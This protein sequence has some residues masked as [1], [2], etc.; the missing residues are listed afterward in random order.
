VAVVPAAAAAALLAVDIAETVL[1]QIV[2]QLVATTISAALAPEFLELQQLS[3]KL[4]NTRA[5][6]P[7]LSI[8]AFIKGHRSE[9]DSKDDVS[10]TGF[11][12]ELWK[13]MADTAGE[14]LPLL[15][16]AEAWRRGLIPKSSSDPNAVSLEKA[17][18]DSRLK[19]AWTP[20]VEAMQ[21]NLAP[22]GTIIEGWL[23]AQVA[24]V[25]ARKL[26]FQNGVDEATGTLMFKAAG[27]PPGPGELF[28]LLNRG[29]IPELGRG[30]DTL[31]LEQ[32]YLETDL[33]DKWFEKWKQLREYRP[34][35]RTITALQRAGAITDA[36]A[37]RM[38]QDEGLTPELAAIY[39]KTAHHEKHAGAK[40]LTKA[41]WLTLYIDQAIDEAELRVR[42]GGL[43]FS[44]EGVDL[45]VQLANL[46][47]EHA[48]K[49][50]A[51]NRIGSLYVGRK[52]D[53]QAAL[54]GLDGIKVP[55]PQRDRLLA[56]WG[57]ER[58]DVLRHLTVA[59]IAN[60]VKDGIFQPDEGLFEM[61]VLGYGPRDAWIILSTHLKAPV[62]PNMPTDNLP[63]E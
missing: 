26:L 31:S 63:P 43:G 55:A 51:I 34:P 45:E 49:Q 33:K 24:E 37:L 42:L 12:G 48:L 35:P 23:R 3:F 61:A 62:T 13:V 16:A 1:I 17:I 8:E 22:V 5:L 27:R 52:V 20:T 15:M 28:T 44:G 2:G 6:D 11:S 40:E 39:I 47:V 38:Y 18:K 59:E 4:T 29:I 32:G 14:P 54:E 19:N 36:Q 46:K 25:D 50:R 9:A 56:L 57:V 7:A 30:G 53:K 60:A 10:A 41:E 21:F 58:R